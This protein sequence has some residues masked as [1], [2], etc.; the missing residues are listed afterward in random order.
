[1]QNLSSGKVVN[2][3][4]TSNS[5]KKFDGVM[6]SKPKSMESINPMN[7]VV[8]ITSRPSLNSI[9]IIKK[10]GTKEDYN[11]QKVISAVKKSAAVLLKNA[12]EGAYTC[13]VYS[14]N[15]NIVLLG[16]LINAV[17]HLVGTGACENNHQIGCAKLVFKVGRH[18]SE[19]LCLAVI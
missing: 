9:K 19:N 17:Y 5:E 18:L 2:L 7:K 6:I 15:G 3:S 12:L 13:A 8:G 14:C 11:I 16:L 1:M 10:D 4:S